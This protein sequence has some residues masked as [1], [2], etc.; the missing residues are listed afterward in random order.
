MTDTGG[1]VADFLL[2]HSV[3]DNVSI[4]EIKTPGAPLLLK[5]A[6]R[7]GVY[8][9]APELSGGV[10]QLAGYRDSL[11]KSYYALVQEGPAFTAFNPRCVL[12]VGSIEEE[13]LTP[14][15]QR[16]FEFFRRE[17]R[18]VDVVTYDELFLRAKALL[19]L[20]RST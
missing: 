1:K 10:V 8:G 5:S 6:Y 9:R 4:L 15:Q 7:S 16:S 12:L 3:L 19:D 13:L 14:E 18:G 17:L 11:L 20:I 2:R